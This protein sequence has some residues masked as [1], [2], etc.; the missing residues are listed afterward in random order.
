MTLVLVLLLQVRGQRSVVRLTDIVLQSPSRKLRSGLRKLAVAMCRNSRSA[1]P[2]L[3][4]Y[5]PTV[6]RV[7]PAV[8]QVQNAST[9][10]L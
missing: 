10:G 1:P 4:W 3:F 6:M 8:T 5:S 7:L 2:S 9:L